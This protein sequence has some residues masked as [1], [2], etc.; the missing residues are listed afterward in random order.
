[1]L[2]ETHLLLVVQTEATNNILNERL[3]A[4]VDNCKGVFRAI[5]IISDKAFCENN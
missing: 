5:Q 3:W 4:L 2:S 1:M